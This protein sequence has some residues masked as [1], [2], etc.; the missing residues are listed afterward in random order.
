MGSKYKYPNSST[1]DKQQQQCQTQNYRLSE[2]QEQAQIQYYIYEDLQ[3]IINLIYQRNA[4]LEYFRDDPGHDMVILSNNKLILQ[5]N[6]SSSIHFDQTQYYKKQ[7]SQLYKFLQDERQKAYKILEKLFDDN[8]QTKNYKSNQKI[9]LDDH[10]NKNKEI[11]DYLKKY[12]QDYE[13]QDFSLNQF[14]Q[15]PTNLVPKFNEGVLSKI[16][17][18]IQTVDSQVDQIRNTQYYKTPNQYEIQSKAK[19]YQENTKIKLQDLFQNQNNQ[20]KNQDNQKINQSNTINIGQSNQLIQGKEQKQSISQ[21][22]S[23]EQY[24]LTNQLNKEISLKEKLIEFINDLRFK[25]LGIINT[26][27]KHFNIQDQFPKNYTD[28]NIKDWAKGF[29]RQDFLQKF[30]NLHY[31]FYLFVEYQECIHNNQSSMFPQNNIDL[32]NNF[33]KNQQVQKKIQVIHLI[34]YL[35]DKKDEISNHQKYLQNNDNLQN[36]IKKQD[37]KQNQQVNQEQDH[38]YSLYE[39]F[40]NYYNRNQN[41]NQFN[42]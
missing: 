37:L 2:K 18:S 15:Q 41:K 24:N 32:V 9:N 10:L 20:M 12:K 40:Y 5:L 6:L 1:F 19:Q 35:F 29:Q 30:I 34:E 22:N 17:S 36:Q 42:K 27:G 7:Q 25:N 38:I 16:I 39:I 28:T 3:N 33:M 4:I 11:K 31:Q 13:K 21:S 8:D 23:D 26:N 14:K